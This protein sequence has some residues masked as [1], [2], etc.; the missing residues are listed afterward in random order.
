MEDLSGFSDLTKKYINNA[1]EIFERIGA[2]I[3]LDDAR[4]LL[5]LATD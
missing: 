5:K 1:I 3:D 2:K 4:E